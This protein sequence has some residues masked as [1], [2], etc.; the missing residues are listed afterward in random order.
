MCSIWSGCWLPNQTCSW[1]ATIRPLQVQGESSQTPAVQGGSLKSSDLDEVWCPHWEHFWK[2]GCLYIALQ[3][4]MSRNGKTKNPQ[5]EG[6]EA[7]KEEGKVKLENY[8]HSL[9]SSI[10]IWWLKQCVYQN[11]AQFTLSDAPPTH[12]VKW[13]ASCNAMQMLHNHLVIIFSMNWTAITYDGLL[14]KFLSD[15]NVRNIIM[16]GFYFHSYMYNESSC[17]TCLT[18]SFFGNNI[19][20]YSLIWCW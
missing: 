4:W 11:E 8:V 13:A 16:N 12:S 9:M 5:L 20:Q 10:L 19:L 6:Q 3:K 2:V 18:S 1:A 17:R 14:A 7:G 15:G